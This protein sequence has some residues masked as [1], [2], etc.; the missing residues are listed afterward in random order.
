M[1]KEKFN[2]GD[3]V[4][5]NSGGPHMTVSSPGSI[6]VKTIW[7]NEPT[8]SYCHGDFYVDT[9]YRVD[10]DTSGESE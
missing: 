2:R 10:D 8:G 7:W 4:R 5:L 9:L 1:E 6:E 3:V